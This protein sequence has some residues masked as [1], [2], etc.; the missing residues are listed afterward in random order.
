MWKKVSVLFSCNKSCKL[1][2]QYYPGEFLFHPNA[3][4]WQQ[5]KDMQVISTRQA[6]VPTESCSCHDLHLKKNTQRRSGLILLQDGGTAQTAWDQSNDVQQN[7][8]TV[9]PWSDFPVMIYPSWQQLHVPRSHYKLL[10]FLTSYQARAQLLSQ[11]T[12]QNWITSPMG[13]GVIIM[14]NS[15]LQLQWNSS[16]L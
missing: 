2:K 9:Q 10:S 1:C 6:L 11:T 15:I 7:L 3:V 13:D 12:Q 5:L 4:L 14:I 16:W 8:R